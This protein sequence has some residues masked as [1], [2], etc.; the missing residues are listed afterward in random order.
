MEVTVAKTA[1]FCFGVKRAVEKVYDQIGRTEKRIYTYGP[2]IH[3]E[4]VVGDLR[5]KGVEV[6]DS[7]E[8]LK[9]I[10]K[11][12]LK[13]IIHVLDDHCPLISPS[14]DALHLRM[15]LTAYDQNFSSFC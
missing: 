6:I 13:K 5:E 15:V 10:R 1:G 11:L 8:E 9:T 14:L 7:L 3:N 2:I 12:Q 4:Q